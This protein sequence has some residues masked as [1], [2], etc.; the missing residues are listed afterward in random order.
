[1]PDIR[2]NFGEGLAYLIE[3]NAIVQKDLAQDVGLKEQHITDYKAGR[4]KGNEA[5]RA[6][7]AERI[8]AGL[9]EHLIRQ[10]GL[11]IRRGV[12]GDE[13]YERLTSKSSLAEHSDET[14]KFNRALDNF[15]DQVKEFLRDRYG[16][17]FYVAVAF[18]EKML[19]RMPKFVQWKREL[20]ED[21]QGPDPP[22]NPEP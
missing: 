14:A 13:A 15:F 16:E 12:P 10:L 17:S 1:M 7:I 4:R 21:L 19:D 6:R 9:S 2:K 8:G 18:E 20:A 5:E 3:R 11:M 22:V